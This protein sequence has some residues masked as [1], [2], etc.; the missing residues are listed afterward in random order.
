MS[1][2]PEQY[3]DTFSSAQV[4]RLHASMMYV[5]QTAVDLLADSH[6]FPEE[7]LFK[8]RWGKGKKD[9]ATTLPNGEKI[10]YITVGGRTSC[11]VPAIQ[12]KTGATAEEGKLPP[13]EDV[14]GEKKPK[15]QA[16]RKRKASPEQPK[17]ESLDEQDDS[18]QKITKK[19][20]VKGKEVKKK[21]GPKNTKSVSRAT[22]RGKKAD[23]VSI[24]QEVKQES[25]PTKSTKI[26]IS[27]KKIKQ[28]ADRP[29][30][31]MRADGG[32]QPRRRSGRISKDN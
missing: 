2:H 11:I 22:G 30:A 28:E 17:E 15:A 9:A 4:K 16:S 5:C 14:S 24:E 12:K 1:R 32:A 27:S 31:G 8:H 29:K 3:S 13:G 7:W 20:A 26:T 25:P 19:N 6:K 23:E 18:D 10:I 21:A